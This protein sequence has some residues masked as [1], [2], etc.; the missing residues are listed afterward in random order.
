VAKAVLAASIAVL[1][2]GILWVGSGGVGPFLTG[3][4]NGFGGLLTRVGAV[5][6]SPKPTPPASLAAAPAIVPPDEPYTNVEAVDLTINVPVS[7]VGDPDYSVRL[8]LTLKD[9]P[10]A[11]VA[12]VPV[13]PTSELTIPGV[14]LAKGRN[15]FQ[16]SIV[17][18]A[19]EGELSAVA[20][21]VLDLSKPKITV[22]SPAANASVA[23]D[24]VTI[25]G[26]TQGRSSVLVRNDANGATAAA[27]ADGAGL[28]EVRV[29]L[30]AGM[31]AITITATDPAGNANSAVLELRKPSGKLLAS[32]TGTAYRLKASK[33]PRDVSFTVV[34]T[35]PD[36]RRV[37]GATA[38]FT[39]TVPGLEA[40]VSSEI[41]TGADGTASF[42]TRIPKGALAGSGLATVLITTADFGTATDRQVLTVQ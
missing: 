28:F 9:T 38:L 19:G 42:S 2:L 8:W 26:K 30:V 20:S 12:E 25:K 36:G 16:A 7:V 41:T 1:G 17:G 6:G 3:V 31:N 39:V 10:A 15:D 27:D 5:V 18:P 35:G 11:V 37:E 13:G 24:T 33:L 21:W 34:V 40:I 23:K 29:A 14:T 22:I 32:L 4:A